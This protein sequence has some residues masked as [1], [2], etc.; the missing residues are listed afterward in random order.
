MARVNCCNL[1]HEDE[2]DGEDAAKD[3]ETRVGRKFLEIG[4]EQ[5][6]RHKGDHDEAVEVAIFT[7]LI[8]LIEPVTSEKVRLTS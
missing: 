2:A 3:E 1:K 8:R 7:A 6:R 4:D 5:E